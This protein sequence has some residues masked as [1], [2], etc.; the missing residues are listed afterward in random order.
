MRSFGLM[1]WERDMIEYLRGKIASIRENCVII[2]VNGVGYAVAVSESTASLLPGAGEEAKI[3]TFMSVKDDGVSLYGFPS[4]DDLEIFKL[5]ITVSGIGPKGALGILS[6]LTPDD[7]RFAILSGDSASIA[8]AP[9][10]GKKSAERVI[11]ELKDKISDRDTIESAFSKVEA[12]G[13]ANAGV[14]S[15]A[16]DDA[17]EAMTSLGYSATDAYKVVKEAAAA[18]GEGAGADELLKA[19]LNLML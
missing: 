16:R 12:G 15:G 11:L 13:A 10:I 1:T 6:V 8:R 5:L 18:L 4:Y 14:K 3:Y 9:G 7:L 2:D 17:V 19:A